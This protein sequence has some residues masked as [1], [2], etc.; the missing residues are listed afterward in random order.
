M[1][2]QETLLRAVAAVL[3]SPDADTLRKRCGEL[4]S[5]A[6]AVPAKPPTKLGRP[7]RN[8]KRD[9]VIFALCEFR[10]EGPAEVRDL[11]W[12]IEDEGR[13]NEAFGDAEIITRESKED[14]AKTVSQA[15]RR[16]RSRN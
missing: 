7:S 2:T 8:E 4:L 1:S 11:L 14:A 12:Q 3:K 15:A 13:W 16:M 10:G 5:V 6:L 9:A